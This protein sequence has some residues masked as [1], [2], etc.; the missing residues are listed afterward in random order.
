M[1]SETL[2][3][4]SCSICAAKPRI[5]QYS[6]S[7]RTRRYNSRLPELIC[8][9]DVGK[10]ESAIAIASRDDDAFAQTVAASG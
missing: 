3:T 9:T 8:T 7:M 4:A 5:D 1:A 6:G 10:L 2:M